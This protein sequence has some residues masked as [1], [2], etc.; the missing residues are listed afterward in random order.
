MS[1]KPTYVSFVPP[2]FGSYSIKSESPTHVSYPQQP[3]YAPLQAVLDRAFQRA[4]AGK[5]KERHA[6]GKDFKDQYII[7]GGKMFGIGGHLY[8]IG[9][10]IEECQRMQPEAAVKELLD[11]I[12]YAAAAIILLEEKEK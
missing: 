1:Y 8:Q 10:K 11:V 12:V 5:G 2:D 3:D 9:K 6:N 4:S 7:L